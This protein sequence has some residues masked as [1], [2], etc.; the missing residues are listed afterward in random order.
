[1]LIGLILYAFLSPVTQS[2]FENMQLTMRDPILRFFVVE[3]LVG[4]G[5][6]DRAGSYRP[7]AVC[8]RRPTP[9]R[10]IAPC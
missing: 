5:G 1:M 8:A 7:C 6:R 2:G 10:V 9:R 4:H 3:H